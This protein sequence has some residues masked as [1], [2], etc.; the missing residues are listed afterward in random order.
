VK[1]PTIEEMGLPKRWQRTLTVQLDDGGEI[2]VLTVVV[3]TPE[4]VLHRHEVKEIVRN[5]RE[6]ADVYE[7]LSCPEDP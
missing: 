5:L 2:R 7:K 1:Y 4:E 6:I 3:T